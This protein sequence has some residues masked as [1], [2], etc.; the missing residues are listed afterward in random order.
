MA[1]VKKW[2]LISQSCAPRTPWPRDC[3]SPVFRVHCGLSTWPSSSRVAGQA[4]D[5]FNG[6]LRLTGI[7]HYL[8]AISAWVTGLC[9]TIINYDIVMPKLCCCGVWGTQKSSNFSYYRPI[10]CSPWQVYS[11]YTVHAYHFKGV[12]PVCRGSSC[13]VHL[14]YNEFH[15]AFKGVLNIADNVFVVRVSFF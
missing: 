14:G 8:T 12:L 4:E 15:V 1:V 11:M 13:G 5:I 6:Q 10:R 7:F 9:V 3:L 2:P